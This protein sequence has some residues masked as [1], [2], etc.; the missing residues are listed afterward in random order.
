MNGHPATASPRPRKGIVATLVDIIRRQFNHRWPWLL[1]ILP[2]G[3]LVGAFHDQLVAVTWLMPW[4]IILATA[5]A[6][7]LAVTP[8]PRARLSLALAV[9]PMSRARLPER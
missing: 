8:R 9:T 5:I 4:T 6:L 1:A 7:A 2:T 3:L